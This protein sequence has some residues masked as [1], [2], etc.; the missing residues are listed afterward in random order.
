MKKV[1]LYVSFVTA[2]VS[3]NNDKTAPRW[4]EKHN[5]REFGAVISMETYPV[6]VDEFMNI[7][8]WCIVDTMLICKN[9]GGEPFYYVFNTNDFRITGKFGRKGNGENE[10]ISP[11]LIPITDTAYT[12][13]DNFR[14]GIYDVT[15]VDSSY[16]I[17]KKKNMGVQ[18][19][20][21]S[22]KF[23]SYLTFGNISYSPREVVWEITDI[24]NLSCSDSIVFFDESKGGNSTLYN[25]SYD[26]AFGHAVFAYL[27]QDGFMIASL[28]DGRHVIPKLAV[29]GD[30]EERMKD[31]GY[32]TDVVCG[33]KCFYVLSQGDVETSGLSGASFIEVYDYEGNPMKKINL[34]IIA[35]H[36]VYDEI[37]KR[38]IFSPSMDN[39]LHVLDYEFE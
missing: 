28:S 29:K 15:K 21:N 25:F 8:E 13:I 3:C 4:E 14:W 23:V 38:V 12:V 39:D 18:I 19:P 37:N 6:V 30:G 10:W 9:G 2:L 11:H 24:E 26:V 20:L 5:T 33:K 7:K 34:D 36:M 22:P 32:Y 17:Q 16:V 35:S 27:Y 1:L 31:G